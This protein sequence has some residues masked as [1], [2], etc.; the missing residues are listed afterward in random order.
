[1][2]DLKPTSAL[3]DISRPLL[4]R[5]AAKSSISPSLFVRQ[6]LIICI[7]AWL[8]TATWVVLLPIWSAAPLWDICWSGYSNN[9]LRLHRRGVAWVPMHC[10]MLLDQCLAYVLRGPWPLGSGQQ[11]WQ[12]PILQ[13]SSQLDPKDPKER[14]GINCQLSLHRK[15]WEP[16]NAYSLHLFLFPFPFHPPSLPIAKNLADYEVCGTA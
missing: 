12:P 14:S 13:T 1:M 16:Q 11:V 4:Y 5:V 15:L 6:I 7:G 2:P 9:L 10:S 3:T 8:G